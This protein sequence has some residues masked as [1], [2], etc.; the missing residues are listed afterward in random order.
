MRDFGMIRA[1]ET[2]ELALSLVGRSTA[3]DAPAKWIAAHAEY[4]MPIVE[5]YASRGSTKAKAI[6]SASRKAAARPSS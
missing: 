2:V 3:K 6:I 1:R 4:A 5:A